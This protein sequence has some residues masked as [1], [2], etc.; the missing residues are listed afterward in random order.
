M[1][2]KVGQEY[3]DKQGTVYKVD[4]IHDLVVSYSIVGEG[5]HKDY[6]AGSAHVG[7]FKQLIA[8]MSLMPNTVVARLLFVK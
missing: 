7:T 3:I 8:D 4:H 2:I 6:H 1:D 5:E